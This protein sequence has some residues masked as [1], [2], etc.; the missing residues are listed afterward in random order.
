MNKSSRLVQHEI[1]DLKTWEELRTFLDGLD[2]TDPF[3]AA[4]G[5]YAKSWPAPKDDDAAFEPTMF[6]S[7][8]LTA[9][10]L[11][12]CPVI[13]EGTNNWAQKSFLSRAECDEK[14][15]DVVHCCAR[16]RGENPD[17][18]FC[19]I[20]IPEK[21]FLISRSFLREDRYDAM[22]GAVEALRAKLVSFDI[23]VLFEQPIQ[24]IE[25]YLSLSDYEYPDSHLHPRNYILFFARALGA[26]GFDWERVAPSVKM[27]K[28]QVYLDLSEKFKDGVDRAYESHE[29]KIS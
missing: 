11:Y 6:L 29:A 28:Q 3:Q 26:L 24:N 14:L 22:L 15:Q 9:T 10:Y 12:S 25:K 5:Y 16:L 13:F 23:P 19:L 17:A 18:R 4:I 1:F 2:S 20:L 21:D 7:E 27:E 8:D